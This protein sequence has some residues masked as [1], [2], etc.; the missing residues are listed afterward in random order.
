MCSFNSS[1]RVYYPTEYRIH[2]NGVSVSDGFKGRE[3]TTSYPRDIL[4]G[5]DAIV[6]ERSF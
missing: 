5:S 4:E 6:L 1:S 3:E 2:I